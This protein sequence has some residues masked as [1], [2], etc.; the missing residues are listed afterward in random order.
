MCQAD[1]LGF[2]PV[3]AVE[4]CFSLACS[5]L[6][7]FVSLPMMVRR[8]IQEFTSGLPNGS[9]Y[10]PESNMGIESTMPIAN[11]STDPALGQGL[12]TREFAA[13]NDFELLGCG[14][15]S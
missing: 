15:L 2:W 8:S 3:E 9:A 4:A 7:R 11:M 13:I 1:G 12:A 6:A 14:I 10:L 5:C